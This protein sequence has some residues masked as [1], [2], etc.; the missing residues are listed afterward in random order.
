MAKWFS[1][2]KIFGKVLV[3]TVLLLIFLVG[4]GLQ[5]IRTMNELNHK[6]QQVYHD[7]LVPLR[8][9]ANIRYLTTS[10]SNDVADHLAAGDLAEMRELEERIRRR[11]EEINQAIATLRNTGLTAAEDQLLAQFEA[12]LAEYRPL[13]AQVVEL[14]QIN[15]KEDARAL[16]T[17]TIPIRN[18]SLTAIGGLMDLNQKL[19]EDT[20][21][22]GQRAFT[23]TAMEFAITLAIAIFIALGF[24]FYLG[25]MMSRP[26]KTLEH[27]AGQVAEGDLR[28][29]WTIRSRDEIGTLSASLHKMVQDL[30]LVVQ[31][32][33]DTASN[34]AASA[35]EL[36]ASTQQSSQAATQITHAAQELASG[37]DRQN[38]KVQATMATIEQVSA[39]TEQIA[40]TPPRKWP[41]PPSTPASEPKMAIRLWPRQWRRWTA[42]TPPLTR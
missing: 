23:Q 41:P 33:H 34:V 28:V 27:A 24:A 29:E 9:L 22:A 26:L 31:Q 7:K 10:N 39:A 20:M 13:R 42:S 12:A 6:T 3:L 35:E 4:I 8:L 11:V 17:I 1:N 18:K 32:V 36:T 40:A 21:K 25:R 19:A 5:A 2:L 38:D 15:L 14:S 16:Y 30:R 37:A